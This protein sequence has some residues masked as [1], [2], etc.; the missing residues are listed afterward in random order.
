MENHLIKNPQPPKIERIDMKS[1]LNNSRYQDI[2]IHNDSINSSQVALNRINSAKNN[3]IL[4][5][6]NHNKYPN[7][8]IEKNDNIDW[9]PMDVGLENL[10]N[11]CFMNSTLQCLL[12]IEPLITYFLQNNNIQS[13]LNLA[14]PKK[15]RLA[16]S[17]WQLVHDVYRKGASSVSP[18]NLQRAVRIYYI[19]C[20]YAVYYYITNI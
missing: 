4:S 13:K 20:I 16:L 5:S 8:I 10:G 1:P 17:F 18:S 14:S 2:G 9:S 12:H 19:Y 11:T 15:G 7:Q 3:T 6:D